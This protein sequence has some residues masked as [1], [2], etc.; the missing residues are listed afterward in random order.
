MASAPGGS[1]RRSASTGA[2]SRR[3]PS[4]PH[5]ATQAT[6][7]RP[8]LTASLS[9][10]AASP[11]K[12]PHGPDKLNSLWRTNTVAVNQPTSVS[13]PSTASIREGRQRFRRPPRLSIYGLG[14]ANR[15]RTDDLLNAIQALSQLSYGPISHG[16][17][18]SVQ[19]G[20]PIVS[21][22]LHI[23]ERIPVRLKCLAPLPDRGRARPRHFDYFP[24][25]LETR[26][27]RDKPDA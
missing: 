6:D 5:K 2:A 11:M 24:P 14:G 27:R 9:P 3:S 10:S 13:I 20:N 17:G 15:N 26:G 19:H 16:F 21:G 18:N 4:T 12:A 7:R 8:G 22:A 25:C 23:L 1:C